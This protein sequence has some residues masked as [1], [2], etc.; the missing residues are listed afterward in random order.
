M[1]LNRRERKWLDL[2]ITLTDVHGAPITG[3]TFEAS[4]DG[5]ATWHAAD[6]SDGS[7]RWLLDGPD[8]VPGDP[9][10]PSPPAGVTPV[11]LAPSATAGSV[12]YHVRAIASP[13]VEI[14]SGRIYLTT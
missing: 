4:F 8:Y 14:A 5:Y 3:A 7:Q 10:M 12:V 6:T 1:E 13:E 2:L 9:G 11:T